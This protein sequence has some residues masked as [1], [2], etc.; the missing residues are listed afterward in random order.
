[1]G[2]SKQYLSTDAIMALDTLDEL[3]LHWA[4]MQPYYSNKQYSN[5]VDITIPI[6]MGTNKK[7]RFPGDIGNCSV[8]IQATNDAGDGLRSMGLRGT[9]LRLATGDPRTFEN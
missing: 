9:T 7:I 8:P 4:M 6:D 5:K 3:A 1:M 2:K